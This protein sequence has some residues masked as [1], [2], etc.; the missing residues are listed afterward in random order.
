MYNSVLCRLVAG[1]AAVLGTAGLLFS[2]NAASISF[3]TY[4]GN[5]GGNQVN[6]SVASLPNCGV[7]LTGTS[8]PISLT[9]A[10]GGTNSKY[11]ATSNDYT[12]S[13]TDA[14]ITKIYSY[15][16]T[17]PSSDPCTFWSSVSQKT[18][19]VSLS[20]STNICYKS[21]FAIIYN[22]CTSPQRTFGYSDAWGFFDHTS[23]DGKGLSFVVDTNGKIIINDSAGTSAGI[24]CTFAGT[25]NIYGT[26][27]GSTKTWS[28]NSGTIA[29]SASSISTPGNCNWKN[30]ISVTLPTASQIE[31][32]TGVLAADLAGL[33]DTLYGPVI[34]T[35][36]N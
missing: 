11:D 19:T 36:I 4:E 22:T 3:A 5:N 29:Q 31:G 32:E 30:Q 23:N 14:A 24:T 7:A 15:S 2:V 34:T 12:L 8:N 6:G 10:S 1:A 20:G 16:L 13:G 9:Y 27:N 35:T 17:A 28:S 21:G 33:S 26:Y 25:P 18:A